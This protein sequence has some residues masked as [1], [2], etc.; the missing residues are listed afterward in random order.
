M[1]F[2]V[3]ANAQFLSTFDTFTRGTGHF[4]FYA[5]FPV[6]VLVTRRFIKIQLVLVPDG[7]THFIINLIRRMV[8]VIS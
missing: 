2:S 1:N 8:H 3:A 7:T 6:G 5:P 4:T